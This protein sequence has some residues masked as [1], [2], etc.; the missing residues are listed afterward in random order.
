VEP[1]KLNPITRSR[2][3]R[4]GMQRLT[5]SV[6]Y[7]GKTPYG[8]YLVDALSELLVSGDQSPRKGGI[9]MNAKTICPT[10]EVQRTTVGKAGATA[11]GQLSCHSL[12]SRAF[13]DPW[14]RGPEISFCLTIDHCRT[15]LYYLYYIQT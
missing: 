5:C 13:P 4:K 12:I 7:G 3:D 14:P 6:G 15:I 2:S 11:A 8:R 1:H 9:V 10:A